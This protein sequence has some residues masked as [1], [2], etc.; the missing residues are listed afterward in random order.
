MTGDTLIVFAILAVTIVFFVGDW[1]RLDLV[2]LLALLALTLTGV[3]TPAEAFAGLSDPLVIMIAGLFV[4]A[5]GMFRSGLAERFGR[6]LARLAGTGRA[7]ATTVVMLGTSLLSAFVS[8]TGTVALLLPVTTTLA[9]RAGMSPSLLLMPMAVGALVGGLLTLIA[10]PPNIIVSNQLVAAGYEPFRFFDFTPVGVAMVAVATAV[11]ALVGG[12]LLPT[13][14]PVKGPSGADG[15]ASLAGDEL[16]QGYEV[17]HIARLRVAADSPLVGHSPAGA[18][19]RQRYRASVVAIRRE[20]GRSGWMHRVHRTAE[21]PLRAGDEIDVQAMPES[22]ARLCTEEG[23]EL[24]RADTEPEAVFAE[25]LLPPRSRLI[26]RTLADVRFRSRYGVNVLSIRRQGDVVGDELATMPLRFADTLLVSGSPKRIA[27]LRGEGGDFVVVAR[28]Q[29]P[30]R[31]GPLS[32]RERAALA[33]LAGMLALLTLELVPPAVAVLL[34]AVGMVLSRCLD[35]RA[36]YLEIN[37]ESVILIAAI[38]PM[39]TALQKTG[40]MELIVGALMP[41]GS[42]GPLAMLVVVFALTGVMGQFVSN[43]A[44]AALVAPVA[45]G[46][47]TQLGVSPHPLLMTVAVA[48]ST[49]F[50]TPVATPANMLIMAQGE[51]RFGDYVRV[52]LPLQL[53]FGI[54]TVIIVPVLFPF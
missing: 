41:L 34:A 2:A 9:R 8:T 20:Q 26:G 53:L 31:A 51:Y 19:L 42:A 25:V 16:V 52:G 6:L 24:L 32:R 15:V 33:V 13:R 7:R 22:V 45:M 38:L 47:A 1:L 39:A 44:T 35:M 12:R 5:G 18:A 23:L 11:L 3:L 27:M 36:A 46:A 54:V 48:A 4:V 37:W 10:T 49:S 17:S 21:E 29:E 28:G 14:A 30:E 43:T 50:A 40:G